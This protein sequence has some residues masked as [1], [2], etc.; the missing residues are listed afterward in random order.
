MSGKRLN[1][2]LVLPSYAVRW[3]GPA[4]VVHDICSG[5]ANDFR[6]SIL[7]TS[8]NPEDEILPIPAGVEFISFNTLKPLSNLWK[9]FAPE[10]DEWLEE[11]IQRFDLV[12][13]HEMW[14]Y[15]QFAATRKALKYGIPYLVSPHGE[16]D[17]W[18]IANKP[19]RKRIFGAIFQKKMLLNASRV[20]A[21]TPHELFSIEQFTGK[22]TRASIIPNSITDVPYLNGVEKIH[23]RKYILFLGRIQKVKG[24]IELL[25]GYT[26]WKGAADYDLLFAGPFEEEKYQR[27]MMDWV[28]RHQLSHRVHFKGL[29]SGAAKQALLH[30]ASVFVLSSFSEGFPVSVLEAMQAG[31]PVIISDHTGIHDLMLENGAAI[32]C[33]PEPASITAALEQFAGMVPQDVTKMVN[34]STALFDRYFAMNRVMQHYREV[35]HSLVENS[36]KP[37]PVTDF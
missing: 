31:C 25:K 6:F 1:I 23:P 12:H 19:I 16:L 7:T 4:R 8:N 22:K 2:L 30:Q 34:Q 32:L 5:L 15:S 37:Q 20:H 36:L 9:S 24:C 33:K 29:V 10:I 11:N 3:G 28:V 18:R 26:H 14:H 13:I 17:T 27:Q 21:L 35:Y